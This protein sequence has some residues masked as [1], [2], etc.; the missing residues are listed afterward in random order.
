MFVIL[1]LLTLSVASAFLATE[2]YGVHTISRI[3]HAIVR[4]V[5]LTVA[6]PGCLV[7][8]TVLGLLDFI[9]GANRH[10]EVIS[11]AKS[12][13]ADVYGSI[14]EIPTVFVETWKGI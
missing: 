5:V 2:L 14:T 6:L 7:F 9:V 10:R 4:R 12:V 3:P 1:F 13:W 11:V 8:G